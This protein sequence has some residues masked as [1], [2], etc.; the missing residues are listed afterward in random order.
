MTPTEREQQIALNYEFFASR[1]RGPYN[2]KSMWEC[3]ME[4]EAYKS[5]PASDGWI[6]SL[7]ELP[8]ETVKVLCWN[9]YRMIQ[10]SWM[11]H[12]D[13]D[14]EWFVHWFTHW[15]PLPAPPKTT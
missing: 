3:F 7:D 14:A 13:Q 15:M 10:R 11:R 8:T 4:S 2:G 1:F 5:I 12:T 6:K 9:G